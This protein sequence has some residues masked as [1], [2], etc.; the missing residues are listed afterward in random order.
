[1]GIALFFLYSRRLMG[2][3]VQRQA[4]AHFTGLAGPQS[5][6]GQA[7]KTPPTR[8]VDP[9]T[10]QAIASRCTEY[11]KLAHLQETC[12]YDNSKRN[13]IQ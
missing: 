12:N 9:R 7:R 6:S 8:G 1:M 11:A 5:R 13:S 10:A 4:P 3:N 2:E